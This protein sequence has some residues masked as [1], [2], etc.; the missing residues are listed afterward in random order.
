[1]PKYVIEREV[2][3][4][5]N[6]SPDQAR[7]IAQKSCTVLRNLGPEIQWIHSYV[8]TDKIYRVCTA[9]NEE[10]IRAQRRGPGES[11]F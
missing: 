11:Y 3:G 7:A 2:G 6:A 9:L 10:M 4:I 5:G 8:T 1:M